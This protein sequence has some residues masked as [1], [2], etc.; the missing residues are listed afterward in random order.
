MTSVSVAASDNVG[1]AKV[2]LRV[3]GSLLA[4][5]TVSP[6]GFSWDTS[7]APNGIANLVARACDAAGNCADSAAVSVNVAN[8]SDIMPP[9][10]SIRNPLAGARV[11]GT[12]AVSASAAD[13][14]GV[15]GLTIQLFINGSR[16]ASS[17]GTGSV[18][19]SWNTRKVAVGTYTLRAD[20]KDAAGNSS[21]TSITVTR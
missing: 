20:A 1:V 11:S 21:S 4:T 12:V 10:V 17:T 3:N 7:K 14:A 5:D 9:T 18:S 8:V 6:F 16:I 15:A 13:N 2:E 19:Y